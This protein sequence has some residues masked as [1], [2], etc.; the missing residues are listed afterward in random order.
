MKSTAYL[1]AEL[2]AELRQP[3]VRDLAWTLLGDPLLDADGILPLRH[4][5]AASRWL[6]EPELLGGWLR[7]QE[8]HSEALQAWLQRSPQQRLGR[9]YERLWQFALQQAPD[10]RL[11]GANL[12]VRDNGHTLGELDL[13]L[14][15]DDGLH[16][17]ELA[18]KLYLGPSREGPDDW[19]G[20]GAE[21]RLANKLRHLREHQ[22]PLSS[23]PHGRA[24]IAGLSSAPVQA[25]LW[26]GGYLFYPW[27][28]E[29]AAPEGA[30]PDHLSGSWLHRRHWPLYR[31]QG[32]GRWQP[33]PRSEWL[34]PARK[35]AEQSW[36]PERF[37]AWLAQLPADAF[38][39]LL[40]RLEEQQGEWY[41]AERLFL[42]GDQWPRVH[43]G[44][45]H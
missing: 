32:S 39:Q 26:L 23:T 17:L 12:A 1:L 28:G 13:L 3:A 34:A 41:E 44:Y 6:A 20:P 11:L 8:R 19:L 36:T 31:A 4:P 40:V 7:E 45:S 33:L 21:D 5:L 2:L 29:C 14:E 27:P 37:D 18:I 35:S 24:L 9:Y 43:N 30:N 22:L 16:H 25:A 10:L 42:V 38:P 15:D